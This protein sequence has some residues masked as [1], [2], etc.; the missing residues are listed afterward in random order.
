MEI[1][2]SPRAE[3]DFSNDLNYLEENFGNK[4]ASRYKQELIQALENISRIDLISYQLVDAEKG[5]HRYRI[6]KNKN[7]Y[8][9]I[10]SEN[11]LEL[12]AFYSNR[13]D[14]DKLS[15]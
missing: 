14:P 7:L 10:V 9:R 12:I 15:L 1:I 13:Q 4:T 3:A 6:N 11:V 8:Y 2:W 5:I